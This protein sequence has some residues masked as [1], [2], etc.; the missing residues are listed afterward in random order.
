M[1]TTCEG[2]A[3]KISLAEHNKTTKLCQPDNEEEW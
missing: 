2:R 1:Q 3:E